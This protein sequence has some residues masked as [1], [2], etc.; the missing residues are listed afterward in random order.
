MGWLSGLGAREFKK[1]TK[2]KKTKRW[3]K[4]GIM[5]K[6]KIPEGYFINEMGDFPLF[7]FYCTGSN[8]N[9]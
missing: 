8:D 3:S 5:K 6:T 2:T 7:Y 1:K 9:L 4:P